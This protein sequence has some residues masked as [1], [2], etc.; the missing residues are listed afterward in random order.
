MILVPPDA[1]ETII[2]FPVSVFITIAGQVD[3]IGLLPGRIKLCGEGGTPKELVTLGELKSSISLLNIMPVFG[4]I[5]T[6]PKLETEKYENLALN[7]F[8]FL[9]FY[10]YL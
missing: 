9:F 10:D 7:I 3:D 2:T 4:D 5:F 1:P 8:E 6:Q